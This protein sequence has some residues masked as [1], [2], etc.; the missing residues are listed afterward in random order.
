MWIMQMETFW[1]K[2][3]S[4]ANSVYI[5]QR[6]LIY[7]TILNAIHICHGQ[8]DH[9]NYYRMIFFKTTVEKGWVKTYQA[10]F[11]LQRCV[12]YLKKIM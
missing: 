12:V 4:N 10:Q 9:E 1:N 7:I 8:D 6:V 11:L 3:F 5:L 2:L